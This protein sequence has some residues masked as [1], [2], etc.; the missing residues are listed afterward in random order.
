MRI[1]IATPLY[2]PD[3]APT[4]LYVKELAKR[5]SEAHEV[6]ILAYAHIPEKIEGIT[7]IPISK[8]RPLPIRL[9]HFAI[10]LIKEARKSD[11]VYAENGASVELPVVL[12]S[13]LTKARFVMHIGDRP[14][15]EWAKVKFFR[16]ILESTALRQ[17]HAVITDLPLPR[18]EILPFGH[19]P[20]LSQY[21]SSWN[22]HIQ[23]LESKFKNGK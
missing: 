14:A 18:P 21:E 23:S 6:T 3:T 1:T 2:P 20:D 5:L 13:L 16:R 9:F 17:A 12:V 4:A 15:H 11:V 8:R 7:I 19:P 22:I 10:S